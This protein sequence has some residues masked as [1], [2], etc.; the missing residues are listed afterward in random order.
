MYM[1]SLKRATVDSAG[2]DFI[3]DED[4]EFKAGAWTEIDTGVCL[5]NK[6]L[7][8]IPSWANWVFL[9]YPRS[10]LG[11]KYGMVFRNPPVIDKDYPGTIKLLIKTDVDIVIQKGDKLCQGIFFPFY[12]MAD[13]E[14]PKIKRTG[15]IGSTGR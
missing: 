5:Y 6:N 11:M 15:G 2:Y 12:T 14:R 1:F 3:S 9:I 4:I 8:E 13:E 7:K 10:S